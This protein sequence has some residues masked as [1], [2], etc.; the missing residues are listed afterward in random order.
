[1]TVS[2]IIA[3]KT[4]TQEAPLERLLTWLRTR[5]VL[6]FIEK[7]A[8]VLDFGCGAHLQTLRAI[9]THDNLRIGIDSCFKKISGQRTVDG[10]YVFGNFDDLKKF[11]I[12]KNAK[13]SMIISLACFEHL[14]VEELQPVLKEL[15]P[16]CAA[17]ARL[18]GT[19]PAPPAKPV[20][21]FLSHRLGL[22]DPSQI[23]DHKVYYDK[24]MLDQA[25]T[26][27]QWKLES[28][29]RFQF[30]FNSFFVMAPANHN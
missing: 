2:D 17:K 27:A 21:E 28:Y 8:V 25:L 1:M 12:S 24:T 29:Q 15:A 6:K 23:A 13:I 11:L 16:L 4:T 19:V 5:R 26:G 3:S 14:Y 9:P 22:I 20:L 10:I 7:G 18:I 30:G